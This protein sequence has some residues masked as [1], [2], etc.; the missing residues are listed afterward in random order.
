MKV[1]FDVLIVPKALEGY[2]KRVAVTQENQ[3][4]TRL[5]CD[6]DDTIILATRARSR[7]DGQVSSRVAR[8]LMQDLMP[9]GGF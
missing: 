7:L 2:C 1:C 3:A 9:L 8:G 5:C 4:T 6:A